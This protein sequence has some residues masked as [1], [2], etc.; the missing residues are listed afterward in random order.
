MRKHLGIKTNK[1]N[2]VLQY[3]VKKRFEKMGFYTDYD[4]FNVGGV[5]IFPHKNFTYIGAGGD[6]NN[7]DIK[8]LKTR[9]HKWLKQR[10]IDFSKSKLEADM[11]NFDYKGHEFGN[12]FLIGDAA[13]L[14]SGLDGEGI[15][16]AIISG[17]E[18]AKK[19]INPKYECPG[20]KKLLKWKMKHE[21][22]LPK[23]NKIMNKIGIHIIM[24]LI[25]AKIAYFPFSIGLVKKKDVV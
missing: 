22:C 4:L 2:L 18:V 17:N 19:I 8:S 10:N 21:R 16:G 15:Y 5:Y 23:S 9:F 6:I 14:A 25:K 24:F 12:I 20:I 3:K 7:K 11:I 13:G 1:M